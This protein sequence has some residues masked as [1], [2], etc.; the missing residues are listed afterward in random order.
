MGVRTYRHTYLGH[1]DTKSG[2]TQGVAAARNECRALQRGGL[3]QAM[4]D[5]PAHDLSA[6][7][8]SQFGQDIGDVLLTVRLLSINS[9]AISPFD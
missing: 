1:T 6:A 7:G 2:H 5:R 3:R 9:L 4:L 8:E